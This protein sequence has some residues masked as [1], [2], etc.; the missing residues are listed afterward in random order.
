MKLSS[1]HFGTF[2]FPSDYEV[3]HIATLNK[4][5]LKNGNNKF[6]HIEG[7][8][9]KDGAKFRLYSRYGRVG[10]HGVE[11]ERVPP[12]DR[13]SLEAAFEH[14][15][16]AKTSSRKGYVEVKLAASKVGS[17]VANQKILSDDIKKD[18][19]TTNSKASSKVRLDPSVQKLV[20]RLYEEAGQAVR[21]QLSGTLNTSVENPLGTL[22][23]S[24]ISEGRDIL[25]EIQRLLVKTPKLIDSINPKLLDLSNKFYSA[26]PQTMEK[27]PRSAEGKPR[28]DAWLGKMALNN[29]S[30]L[31]DKEDLLEL[32]SDVKGM[33]GGF[34][35]TDIGKKYL[36]IGCEYTPV[37]KGDSEFGRVTKFLQDT[38][39]RHHRWSSSLVNLWVVEIKGQKDKHL[40][41]MK[42]VG[43]VQPLFHGSRNANI[44]GI[45]K[46][47]LLLRPPG[48]YITG[49]MFG[50]GLYFADQSSKSEQYSTGRF[51]G[52]RGGGNT[53]FM[54][55]ADIALGRIKKYQRA[56][57]NL[58]KPPQGYDSVQGTKG[59]GL[60]HNEFIIY[61]IKQHILQ[62]LVEFK[63]SSGGYW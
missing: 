3:V 24:Q 61:D 35:T 48:V 60:L 62:Y 22:T 18:K 11:E 52:G 57:T 6:Y 23:L 19:V 25:Q 14:L 59:P 2:P 7:H 9:S 47:G 36:E 45:C 21:S 63:P 55:I 12:Q 56:Q 27:R 29:D 16:K 17:S 49:S 4:A 13:E 1:Q 15:K 34:A 38:R 46:R 5:D 43:K 30:I 50:N 42:K 40:P 37:D 53:A 39:S 51:G 33:V 8:A 58:Q 26:I 44:L 20:K 32:L 10:A 41:T 54:F 28:M 31:D